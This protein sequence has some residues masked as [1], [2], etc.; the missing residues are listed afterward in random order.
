MT[1][2]ILISFVFITSIFSVYLICIYSLIIHMDYYSGLKVE[3]N[4]HRAPTL[5]ERICFAPSINMVFE[6]DGKVKH[7]ATI[8]RIPWVNILRKL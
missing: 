5:H 7:A 3:F 1:C 4:K 2:S 6:T 8:V